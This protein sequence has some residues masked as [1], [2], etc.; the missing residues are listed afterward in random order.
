MTPLYD[1][2]NLF[3][4]RAEGCAS[5]HPWLVVILMHEYYR[6]LYPIDPYLAFPKT[7]THLDRIS[8]VLDRGLAVLNQFSEIASYFDALPDKAKSVLSQLRPLDDGRTSEAI[9]QRVY[10]ALWDKFDAEAYTQE[11]LAILDQRFQ[12]SGWEPAGLKG[13]TV[14]DMGCGSGRY[15]MA[16]MRLGAAQVVGVDRGER[17]IAKA[18]EIARQ[19]GLE[20]IEFHVGDVLQ[21][22]FP[23]A[24]FDFVF[25]NGVLHHTQD[26]E[27]GLGEL[28]RVLKPGG[29]AFLYLYADGGVFWYSRKRMPVIMKRI[30]QE[31]TMAVLDLIG[32]PTGRFI[33][34]DNWYVPIERHTSREY[35]ETFLADLGFH[36]IHKLVSG[37]TTDLDSSECMQHPEAKSLWGDGEHR[38]LLGK[39]DQA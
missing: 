8:A 37:R 5:S 30:P 17:S 1:K 10:G 12:G 31:Y 21:L 27:A 16:L 19:A 7:T 26:M 24:S 36:P 35:L 3:M 22:G 28:H 39:P 2:L 29:Q 25:C 34:A 11:T 33:F 14:L 9:T 6:N 38:Y 15:S 18:R 13:Q 23:D 4:D 20:N 32:M